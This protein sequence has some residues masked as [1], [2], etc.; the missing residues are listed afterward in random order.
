MNLFGSIAMIAA[1]CCAALPLGS[2]T[3]HI[4][5]WLALAAFMTAFGAF[6]LRSFRLWS[7]TAALLTLE[8][9]FFVLTRTSGQISALPSALFGLGLVVLL[10]AG[11]LHCLEAQR[12]ETLSAENAPSAGEATETSLRIAEDLL[13]R[14]P[15]L[16]GIVLP[17]MLLLELGSESSGFAALIPPGRTDAALYLLGAAR[18]GLVLRRMAAIMLEITDRNDLFHG[19][20]S[21]EL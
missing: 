18:A 8:G 3:K 15:L 13:K 10:D 2:S 19:Q 4:L 16:G 7:A 6:R 20:N 12:R 21:S 11:Y 14:T 9:S 1:L 17:P 5:P